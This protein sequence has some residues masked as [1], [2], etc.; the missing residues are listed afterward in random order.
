SK[1]RLVETGIQNSEYRTDKPMRVKFFKLVKERGLD[2]RFGAATVVTSFFFM[3]PLT[4]LFLV[5]MYR[6]FM[7][8]GLSQDKAT[9]LTFLFGFGTP[10]FFRTSHLNHNMFVM[11]AMFLSFFLMWVRPEMKFP[12]SAGRRFAAG[13]F[14]GITLA[15][16]YIGLVLMPV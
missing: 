6:V 5:L 14:A 9:E 11:Y 12:V 4:A 7:L 16:D 3:A 1:R 2:L 15:T 8:R 10:I 13:L